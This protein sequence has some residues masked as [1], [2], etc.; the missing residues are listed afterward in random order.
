MQYLDMMQARAGSGLFEL[1][2]LVEKWDLVQQK[3]C[4]LL[5]SKAGANEISDSAI[6]I[7][8]ALE[9]RQFALPNVLRDHFLTA[10]PSIFKL[11]HINVQYLRDD[12]EQEYILP[13]RSN[14]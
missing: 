10:Y 7:Q 5:T 14:R 4:L 8:E 6:D 9:P 3:P 12:Q 11:P 2:T 1:A 13:T